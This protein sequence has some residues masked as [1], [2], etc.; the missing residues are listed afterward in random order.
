MNKSELLLQVVNES[1]LT[2]GAMLKKIDLDALKWEP[3]KVIKQ[4]LGKKVIFIGSDNVDTIK[5]FQKDSRKVD[6]KAV[7]NRKGMQLYKYQECDMLEC[8]MFGKS[9]LF[10]RSKDHKI[11]DEACTKKDKK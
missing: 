3:A 4:I 1:I 9:T 5:S 10:F 6:H 7:M 2:R 8:Q 11:I